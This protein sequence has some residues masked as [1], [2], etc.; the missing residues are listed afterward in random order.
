MFVYGL[1]PTLRR[2]PLEVGGRA[3]R[4]GCGYVMANFLFREVVSF[5]SCIAVLFWRS[6][7]G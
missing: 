3:I 4:V 1:L 6:L 5:L 2:D 7:S